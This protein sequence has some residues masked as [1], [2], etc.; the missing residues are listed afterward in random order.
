MDKRRQLV[1]ILN[2]FD[3]RIFLKHKF[4]G[5]VRQKIS[6]RKSWFPPP[7]LQI[8]QYPKFSET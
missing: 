3:T 7:M 8:F 4:F 1:V 2:I 6:D 5:T